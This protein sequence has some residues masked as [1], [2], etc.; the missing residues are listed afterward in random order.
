M[1]SD[2]RV[3]DRLVFVFAANSGLLSAAIDS[4]R[5]A[6]GEALEARWESRPW[7]DHL[8]QLIPYE[9]PLEPPPLHDG[10]LVESD[11][12]R[13]SRCPDALELR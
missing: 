10:F 8:L 2:P 1:S 3:I 5:A 11:V 4:A 7:V 12:R 13:P 9:G 6:Q